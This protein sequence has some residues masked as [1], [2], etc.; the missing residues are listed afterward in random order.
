MAKKKKPAA[1]SM[2]R[3]SINTS[4]KPKK[5]SGSMSIM[6]R[7]TS[8]FV[9]ILYIL[10]IISLGI[11]GYSYYY[12]RHFAPITTATAYS[13]SLTYAEDEKY[14][15]EVQLFDNSKKNGVLAYE[16]RANYYTDTLLP[17]TATAPDADATQDEI[18]QKFFKTIYSTGMQFINE[19]N[20]VE[21]HKWN[22]TD[23][24][25]WYE[26]EGAYYYNASYDTGFS[27]TNKLDKADKW[28]IDFG[29]N[30]LGMIQQ[31][32][33]RKYLNTVLWWN[34]YLQYDANLFIRDFLKVMESLPYGKQVVM[35][36]LSDYFTFRYFNTET[37]QFDIVQV[38]EKNLYANILVNKNEN[39]M[40]YAEQSIFGVVKDDAEW[41]YDGIN[42]DNYYKSTAAVTLSEADFEFIEDSTEIKLKDAAIIYYSAFNPDKLELTIN[43]YLDNIDA[44]GF[45]EKWCGA[46]RPT[47]VLITSY[48]A[49][50]FTHYNNLNC[51]FITDSNVALEVIK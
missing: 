38:T 10:A 5:K 32:A 48:V 37:L 31:E 19:V 4:P 16:F 34:N 46:L 33:E 41:A 2:P 23:T 14:A 39:G 13:D 25:F 42:S 12:Y 9:I 45:A 6:E 30:R 22:F 36:D 24:D 49:K 28:V 15:F 8:V 47:K 27:A 17:D 18:I 3:I 1:K 35:F 26:P 29:E 21:H 7:A 43:L 51:T 20:F 40:I 50:T 11:I 44:T